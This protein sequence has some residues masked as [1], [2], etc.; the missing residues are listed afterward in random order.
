MPDTDDIARTKHLLME[1]EHVAGRELWCKDYK[2][3]HVRSGVLCGA[4]DDVY[5][6]R[7]QEARERTPTYEDLNYYFI[8]PPDAEYRPVFVVATFVSAP[9]DEAA[10]DSS[11]LEVGW[12]Q[13]RTSTVPD[14]E[15]RV[16]LARLPWDEHAKDAHQ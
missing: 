3:V 1:I 2:A 16:A 8:E 11:W 5:R 9:I 14:D 15:N 10:G 7:L 6:D 4:V 13:K 12:F